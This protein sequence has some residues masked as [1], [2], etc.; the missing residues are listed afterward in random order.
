VVGERDIMRGEGMEFD[1]LFENAPYLP[2]TKARIGTFDLET[3]GQ[4]FQLREN[5]NV[6]LPSVSYFFLVDWWTGRY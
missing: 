3:L 6:H 1:Q 4:A 2:G 5:G